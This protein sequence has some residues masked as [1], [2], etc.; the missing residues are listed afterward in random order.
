M[1]TNISFVRS[2]FRGI[3]EGVSVNVPSFADLA[4]AALS[5]ASHPEVR[6]RPNPDHLP[7]PPLRLHLHLGRRLVQLLVY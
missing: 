5:L 7:P 2:T 1:Q 3:P 4:V 6:F